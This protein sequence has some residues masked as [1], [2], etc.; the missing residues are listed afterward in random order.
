MKPERLALLE[1]ELRVLEKATEHLGYSIDRVQALKDK[2]RWA[3]E[4]LERFESLASRFSRLADLHIQRVMRLI[5]DLELVPQGSLLDRIERAEKRGWI[6]APDLV[7][8]RELRN[9]IAHEYVEDK[10]HE[11]HLA[12]LELAP[13]L[14]ELTPKVAAFGRVLIARYGGLGAVS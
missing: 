7:R 4:E 6:A 8:I 10:L 1:D 5:D 14:I 2:P 9:L 13:L 3:P 12:V 11:L